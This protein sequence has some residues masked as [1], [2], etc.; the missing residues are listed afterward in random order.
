MENTVDEAVA[1][2]ES[3]ANG[4][5]GASM[6]GDV[7]YAKTRHAEIVEAVKQLPA[8]VGDAIRQKADEMLAICSHQDIHKSNTLNWAIGDLLAPFC[9]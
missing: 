8:E 6:V 2:I 3:A 4:I 5:S 7:A 1:T 9:D